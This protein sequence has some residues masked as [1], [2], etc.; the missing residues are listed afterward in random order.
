MALITPLRDGMNLVAKE[1]CACNLSGEGALFLSEFAGTATQLQKHA[2]LVNPHDVEGVAKAI[3]RAFHM[4]VQERRRRM[5]RMREI[6]RRFD[7][8]WW[9]DSFLRAAF[10]E[11]LGD[12][13]A[14]EN[15]S[16]DDSTE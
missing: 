2:I 15:L 8:F 9:V 5:H 10:N 3:H 14:L 6:N 12:V 4:S 1:Y 13:P 7:I 11:P 16:Y